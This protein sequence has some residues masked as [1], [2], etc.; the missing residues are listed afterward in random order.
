MRFTIRNIYHFI[1]YDIPQ[2]FGN[3]IKWFPVIW[4]DRDWDHHF[5]F[6]V[7]RFKL[8]NMEWVFSKY[9]CGIGSER[10]AKRMRICIELIKRI[11]EDNYNGD[12]SINDRQL[13]QDVEYL[14]K[15]MNKYILGWWD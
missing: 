3:L 10:D 7:L 11:Q 12:Y 9:G 8:E 14:F 6:E 13:C 5:L 1:I 15:L 4:R 2:G